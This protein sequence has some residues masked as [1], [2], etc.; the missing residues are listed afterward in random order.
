MPR[1]ETFPNSWFLFGCLKL[2]FAF[3]PPFL[4]QAGHFEGGVGCTWILRSE[5]DPFK[6]SEGGLLD[7]L[8]MEKRVV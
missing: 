8:A 1:F 4:T 5:S 7:Q 6:L 2:F 3:A